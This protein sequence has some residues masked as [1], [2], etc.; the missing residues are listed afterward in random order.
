MALMGLAPSPGYALIGRVISNSLLGQAFL[1]YELASTVG[2]VKLAR[3]ALY[4]FAV[5]SALFVYNLVTNAVGKVRGRVR[6]PVALRFARHGAREADGGWV[7]GG[8]GRLLRCSASEASILSR[9]A[10]DDS[11]RWLRAHPAPPSAGA[12]CRCWKPQTARCSSPS[13]LC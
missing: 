11:Q 12:R 8:G 6:L 10:L 4:V 5:Q 3:Y 13:S 9:L 2:D 1:A 7:G